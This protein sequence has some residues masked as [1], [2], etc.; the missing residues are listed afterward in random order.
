M[1]DTPTT[2]C[3]R[4]VVWKLQGVS[5]W[6]QRVRVVASGHRETCWPR[7]AKLKRR[8]TSV[9]PPHEPMG[10][11]EKNWEAAQGKCS[12]PRIL[13]QNCTNDLDGAGAL[14]IK[15]KQRAE[16][17]KSTQKETYSTSAFCSTDLHIEESV[18]KTLK[19]FF[20]AQCHPK[21]A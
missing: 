10:R 13:G 7:H 21:F 18:V 4:R 16:L 2:R 3:S 15:S 6:H 1:G 8:H 12:E 14:N 11:M 20:A 19:I 5:T 9:F 17:H